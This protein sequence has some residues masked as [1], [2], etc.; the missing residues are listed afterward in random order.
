MTANEA[1]EA[2][3]TRNNQRVLSSA[4]AVVRER[5]IPG[6]D[7]SERVKKAEEA[8][9]VARAQMQS[10]PGPA[11][12]D[13]L[14]AA[15]TLSPFERELLLLCAGVELEA[16][17]AKYISQ[18][19]GDIH[20]ALPT[21]G[22]A[23]SILPE[24]HWSALG[25][26]S[27]LRQ[28]HLIDVMPGDTLTSS[29]LR[30]DERV[31][32]WL[33]GVN[34]PDERLAGGLLPL[35][36]SL[37]LPPSQH[38]IA[39]QIVL[40]L[41]QGRMEQRLPVIELIGAEY[42]EKRTIA[43]IACRT[44]GLNL[45]IFSL[46]AVGNIDELLLMRLLTREAA[47]QGCA[48][49]LD[50]EELESAETTARLPMT[51]RLAERLSGPLFVSGRERLRISNRPVLVFDIQRPTA[52]E[53]RELWQKALSPMLDNGEPAPMIPSLVAQFDMGV[54][55]IQSVAKEAASALNIDIASASEGIGKAI[56]NACR[57]SAR[58]KLDDLAQR[59]EPSASME[60]LVLPP[61]QRSMLRQ[62]IMHVQKRSKVYE[63]WGFSTKG[64]RGL[65]VAALFAGQSGTG[66]TMAA[67]V[68]AGELE[69]DLYRIDLSQVV[70][71]YIGETEKNLRRV[72]DAAE[73]GASILLFD[74]ADA[75]FG[76]RSEVKD[77]HD[78]YANIEVAYLLQRMESYRGLSIL[79]T[80]L[81]N[82]LDPA[83][84]RRI[85][86]VVHFP[87]PGA[88]ERAEIWRRIFPSKTPTEGLDPV[89]LS[90]FNVAG[91][92]I[93]N[94]AMNAAFLAAGAGEPVRMSHILDAAQTE[95]AKLERTLTGA[96]IGGAG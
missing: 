31:L 92:N 82:A 39:E 38:K 1:L 15:F 73:Q 61:L 8:L 79:T 4:L 55:T 76:K 21:F 22:L 81:K 3:W 18:A 29:P 74:E 7:A 11:A 52:S 78:R 40:A 89:R 60:D 96:E 86:F 54:S 35:S 28:F 9:L 2:V 77:S 17:F 69:L 70:S 42:A 53:Q 65:G 90:K 56:W 16:S 32:H 10:F 85:R 71:K 33:A 43:A 13:V 83:F 23:L 95:Y 37:D 14:T 58:P 44:M 36:Q 80:N 59:I 51:R 87:F 24:A 93:R 5:L 45:M 30:I 67:E 72:F 50:T 47:L 49:L 84:M 34:Q 66:K 27:P 75:L 63:D 26:Q 12:L 88:A 91:G 41:T 6:D 57:A 48:L 20:R 64:L 62:I 68:L 46:A 25:P 94:I 19:H